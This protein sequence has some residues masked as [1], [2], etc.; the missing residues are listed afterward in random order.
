MLIEPSNGLTDIH[1]PF[2]GFNEVVKMKVLE[3]VALSDASFRPLVD[4]DKRGVGVGSLTPLLDESLEVESSSP[5]SELPR[6]ISD[7]LER[8][9]IGVIDSRHDDWKRRK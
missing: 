8:D 3:R 5:I 1:P 2:V 6:T 4:I 7:R 9:D